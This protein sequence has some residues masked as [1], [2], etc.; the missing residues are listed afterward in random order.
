MSEKVH[1]T[2]VSHVG[3]VAPV[4]SKEGEEK[5]SMQKKVSCEGRGGAV[6]FAEQIMAIAGPKSDVALAAVASASIASR[7]EDAVRVAAEYKETGFYED[8]LDR[9]VAFESVW[10]GHS[11]E[12]VPISE[13]ELDRR[14]EKYENEQKEKIKLQLTMRGW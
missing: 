3:P 5:V 11:W 1:V 14:F 12:V 6:M 2:P 4:S 8:E 9:P 10:N 7:Y 13:R